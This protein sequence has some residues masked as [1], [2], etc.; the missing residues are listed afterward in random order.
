MEFGRHDWGFTC[1][2]RGKR[3]VKSMQL[4]KKTLVEMTSYLL[5]CEHLK[6]SSTT[7]KDTRLRT[8][9]GGKRPFVHE[10]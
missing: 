3:H 1:S 5:K 7:R 10:N 6:A 9:S 4:R 2:F 8:R